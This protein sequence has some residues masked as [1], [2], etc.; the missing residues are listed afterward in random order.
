VRLNGFRRPEWFAQ[1][2]MRCSISYLSAKRRA[3]ARMSRILWTYL[4]VRRWY[5][6]TPRLSSLRRAVNAVRDGLPG[7]AARRLKRAAVWACGVPGAVIGR[8]KRTGKCP[9]LPHSVLST[10]YS[11]LGTPARWSFDRKMEELIA[12]FAEVSHVTRKSGNVVSRFSITHSYNPSLCFVFSNDYQIFYADSSEY[13]FSRINLDGEVKMIVKK[14]ESFHSISQKEK[15]KIYERFSELAKQWP[16]G[17]VKEA[18]QFPTHRPFFDSIVIDEKGR[19]FIKKVKPVLDETK[20]VEF[21]IFD[22]EGYYLYRTVL[23]FSPEVI[24]NGYFY[25]LFTSDETGEV[26]IIRYKVLNWDRIKDSL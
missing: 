11:V 8:M 2:P 17:V 20:N 9:R 7:R 21:D 15:D 18:V 6:C 5:T 16:E 23:P 22:R 14:A 24:K 19:T 1:G 13:S 26:K 12:R 4:R 10:Q 25:D 3:Q